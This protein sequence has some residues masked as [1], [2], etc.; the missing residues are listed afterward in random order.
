MNEEVREH[1]LA[2]ADAI[3]LEP[4]L[5]D[6]RSYS[7]IS[8]CNTPGCVAGWSG[9][10]QDDPYPP[11]VGDSYDGDACDAWIDRRRTALGLSGEALFGSTWP[12]EW[13]DRPPENIESSYH[14]QMFLP[15]AQEAVFVLRRYAAG[16]IDP[17]SLYKPPA[18]VTY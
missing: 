5:Y 8:K 17:S 13:L 10:L 9:L 1:V 14:R 7:V 18:P 11:G 15:T 3:E 2:V 12:S 4:L 16:D 6:Q